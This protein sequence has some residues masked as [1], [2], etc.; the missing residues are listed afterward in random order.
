MDTDS[1][2]LETSQKVL[3]KIEL[4]ESNKSNSMA[5]SL[6]WVSAALVVFISAA[7][8][9][10]LAWR[11][12]LNWFAGLTIAI[13]FLSSL[14]VFVFPAGIRRNAVALL[15]IVAAAGPTIFGWIWVLYV[16]SFLLMTFAVI[17]SPGRTR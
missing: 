12:S 7:L 6:A 8:F 14:T 3:D 5:E 2:T 16:P 13:G 15:L 4:K 1:A 10:W 9:S 11:Q 17:A